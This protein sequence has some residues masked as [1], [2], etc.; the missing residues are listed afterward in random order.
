MKKFLLLALMSSAAF[1][2]DMSMYCGVGTVE[3]MDEFVASGLYKDDKAYAS[4]KLGTIAYTVT[5][6]SGSYQFLKS[7]TNTG[8]FELIES[9]ASGDLM[10]SDLIDGISCFIWD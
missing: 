6:D 9:A 7:D 4:F 2:G 5:V 8:G 3:T 10:S 1:A